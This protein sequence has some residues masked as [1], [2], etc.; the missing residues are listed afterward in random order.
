[1]ESLTSQPSARR[2]IVKKKKEDYTQEIILVCVATA[3]VVLLVVYIAVTNLGHSSSGYDAIKPEKPA[4]ESPRAK[5][6]E[7][8]KEK[9][10]EIEKQK[11]A[12]AH[13]SASDAQGGPSIPFGE[14]PKNPAKRSNAAGD[15]DAPLPTPHTFGGPT[16]AMDSPDR[17]HPAQ[18]AT[19][20][21]GHD[22]PQD[23]GGPNDPVMETP[24]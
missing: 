9:E 23:L 6:E 13:G 4:T 14:N 5:L 18:P 11:Q 3:A 16:R 22:T 1:L 10:K 7:E 15:V 19:G 8:R 17:G 2:R 12:A 24:K 21:V 20:T